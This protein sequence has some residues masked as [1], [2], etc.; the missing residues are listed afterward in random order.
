MHRPV[1]LPPTHIHTHPRALR[2]L[3]GPHLCVGLGH[4]LIQGLVV[5]DGQLQVLH[6]GGQAPLTAHLAPGVHS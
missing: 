5:V 3:R 2:V 1:L 4:L 6:L